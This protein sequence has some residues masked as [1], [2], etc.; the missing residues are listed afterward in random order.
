M[1]H[2]RNEEKTRNAVK[3]VKSQS[4]N[5]LV[6]MV[7]A[8][9]SSF[10][11]IREMSDHLHQRY[12]RID[13]LINNAGVQMHERQLSEDGYEMTFAVNHLA[14][15]L[16]TSLL[17]DMIKKSE[18]K[19]IVNVAS[20]LHTDHINF[21]DLQGEKE[22]SLYTNYAQSKLCNIMFTYQLAER[23]EGTGIT[24][25]CAHPGLVD[26]NLNPSRSK[27]VVARAL[28]VEQGSISTIYLATSPEVEQVTGKYF[29][30]DASE[31]RSRE[32]SYN[33]DL[34]IRLWEVSEKMIGEEFNI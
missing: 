1:M 6:D 17:L 22:Y 31:G 25:N 21:E 4:G 8:D 7:L 33:K 28:P 14:Y 26:T 27:D 20:Q 24:A 29:L 9:L 19:R 23:L 10:S 11:Q 5:D 13:V 3:Y 12:D 30:N 34:Q 32:V 15:F 18:Y 16:L 2:G